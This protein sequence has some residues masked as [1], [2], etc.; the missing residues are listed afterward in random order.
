MTVSKRP[1]RSGS[2]ARGGRAPTLPTKA[3]KSQTAALKDGNAPSK[4]TAKKSEPDPFKEPIRHL[5]MFIDG[6][7]VS[8]T[9]ETEFDNNFSNI[10]KLAVAINTNADD[11]KVRQYEAQIG[12]YLAGIGSGTRKYSEGIRA[13]DLPYDIAHVYTNICLNYIPDM[14]H[15]AGDKIYIFGF[16]R[17]AFIARVVATLIARFGLLK[18]DHLSY[19]PELWKCVYR[20][21]DEI[22]TFKKAHCHSLPNDSQDVKIEFLGLFDTVLGTYDGENKNEI[23]KLFENNDLPKN[24]ERCIH[25]LAADEDR[26]VFTPVIWGGVEDV[27]Q[28]TLEQ[29]WMPG[30]HTD[31][32]GGYTNKLLGDM[33]L[34]TILNRLRHYTSVGIDDVSFKKLQTSIH[35]GAPTDVMIHYEV[36]KLAGLGPDIYERQT[37]A[38]G[39]DA[40]NRSRQF[41]SEG[42]QILDQN[43]VYRAS[44]GKYVNFSAKEFPI[45]NVL[46]IG[47]LK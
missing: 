4:P 23:S 38:I 22:G 19:F 31:I 30:V 41:A 46:D 33:S 32:G 43:R 39:V 7:W 44:L 40:E 15:G 20:T 45:Q 37:R 27:N 8:A 1:S 10:Y 13:T 25:V 6:T 18:Q 9:N 24:I 28:Q 11:K 16:S 21:P 35:D 26:T 14:G 5:M 2:T 3:S 17:G 47:L 29:I 12:F 36:K 42:I 34:L